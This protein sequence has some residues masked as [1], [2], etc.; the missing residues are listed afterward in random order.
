[1]GGTE[2]AAFLTAF[3]AVPPVSQFTADYFVIV[4]DETMP[5]V[6]VVMFDKG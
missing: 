6:L 5:N 4:S 1:M 2:A 3:N